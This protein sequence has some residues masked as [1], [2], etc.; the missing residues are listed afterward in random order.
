M[1]ANRHAADSGDKYRR[2]FDLL[3]QKIARYDVEPEN[4]Y[5]IDE[6][7][8]MIGHVGRS[9]RVFSKRKY[10]KKQYQQSL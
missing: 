9:K 1:D 3:E 7:G 8:F 4:T 6:K 5:N 2:Y 10:I